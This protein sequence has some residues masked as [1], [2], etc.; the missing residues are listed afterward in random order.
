MEPYKWLP[1]LIMIIMVVVALF[2]LFNQTTG[3]IKASSSSQEL[4]ITEFK[5]LVTDRQECPS[6]MYKD[7]DGKFQCAITK[8][9][10]ETIK[11]R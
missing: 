11:K 10:D 3:E 7:K 5:K 8:I 9:K 1:K 2:L 4:N 6:A